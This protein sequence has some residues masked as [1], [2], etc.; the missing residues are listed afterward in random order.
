MFIEKIPIKPESPPTYKIECYFITY[1][2]AGKTG[3][4]KRMLCIQQERR[5]VKNRT[6]EI[7][8]YKREH[9]SRIN[10]ELP[11]EQK[12]K[13]KEAAKRSGKSLNE[14]IRDKINGKDLDNL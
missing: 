2:E 1:V 4:K 14:Y 8:E 3:V 11:P 9:Y 7:N 13:W 12:Q 10:L 5:T 6:A